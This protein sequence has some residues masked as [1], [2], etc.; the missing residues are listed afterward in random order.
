MTSDLTFYD[1]AYPPSSPPDVDGACVYIGGD[2]PHV[3]T[4]AE[5][6]AQRARYRLPVFV[7][8]DPGNADWKA[9]GSEAFMQL[10]LIGCPRGSLVALDM[11]TAIDPDY[12][13]RFTRWLLTGGYPVILYGSDSTVFANRIPDGLYF[14]ADWTGTAHLARGAQMTQYV[15]YR[16]WDLDL[17]LPTLPF[18]DTRPPSRPVP[19]TAPTTWQE[20]MMHALP[21]VAEG[22]SGPAVRTVQGLINARGHGC[23]IDGAYGPQTASAVRAIQHNAGITADGV[24]GPRTWPVLMGVQ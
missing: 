10:G 3:W 7:R 24:T 13:L 23:T 6:S 15:S 2:T 17:A 5:I 4:K 14:A 20:I 8:S 9:D 1:A 16:A 21:V 19:P 11:E 12:V 18:W 22:Q